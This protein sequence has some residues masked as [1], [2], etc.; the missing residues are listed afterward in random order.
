MNEA[1]VIE[2]LKGVQESLVH[3]ANLE[4]T[5]SA[6]ADLGNS[7]STTSAMKI[8]ALGIVKQANYTKYL[9]MFE[10]AKREGVM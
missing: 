2:A 8:T 5:K 3:L 4:N 1:Q 7:G 10:Q 9:N 6:S